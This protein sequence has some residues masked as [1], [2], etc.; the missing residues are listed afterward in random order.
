M[1]PN[2]RNLDLKIFL[3]TNRLATEYRMLRYYRYQ[4]LR[5]FYFE[6]NTS[7]QCHR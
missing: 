7:K 5:F 1:F 4:R 6:N 2:H 3:K